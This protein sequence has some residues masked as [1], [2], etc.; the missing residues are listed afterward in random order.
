[1]SG[2]TKVT[3]SLHIEVTVECPE[4]EDLINLMEDTGIGY[5][6]EDGYVIKQACP[7]GCWHTEHESFSVDV[8]CPSCECNFEASG[9]E[10]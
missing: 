10:W 8:T 7:D 2:L 4:C 9:I 6:N 5:Y 1:M 3:A